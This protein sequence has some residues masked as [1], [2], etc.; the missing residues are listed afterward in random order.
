[1]INFSETSSS[2]QVAAQGSVSV[3]LAA[4]FS[5]SI[6]KMIPFLILALIV[7]LVD[8]KFGISAANK[9]G[10]KIRASRAMRRTIDKMISYF[11]W[12]LLAATASV[13]FGIPILEYIIMGTVI[14]IECLSIVSNWLEIKGYRIKGLNVI[15][16]VGDKLGVDVGDA[17]IAKIEDNI[18]S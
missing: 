12:V 3:V 5:D 10:E 14:S 7:I 11:C 1:M 9:R 16:V 2:T 17:T 15:K 18:T 6:T 8:L 4:F 13:A